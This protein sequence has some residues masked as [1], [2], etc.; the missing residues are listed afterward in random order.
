MTSYLLPEARVQ[1]VR[2][3]ARGVRRGLASRGRRL[4]AESQE[5]RPQLISVQQ[6]DSSS[7][8]AG[9]S[10]LASVTTKAIAHCRHAFRT[11]QGVT[12]DRLPPYCLI[13][14]RHTPP[15]P[16]P[17]PCNRPTHPHLPHSSPTVMAHPTHLLM[18]QFASNNSFK[19]EGTVEIRFPVGARGQCSCMLAFCY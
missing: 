9:T 18:N 12:R 1:R 15:P 17:P 14:S 13:R 3:G 7:L 19:R 4:A 2:S 10:R 11:Q 6:T 8:Q 5:S 16:P